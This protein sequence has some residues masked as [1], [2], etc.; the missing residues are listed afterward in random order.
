MRNS[1]FQVSRASEVQLGNCL[2][3]VHLCLH[4]RQAEVEQLLAGV[5]HLHHVAFRQ[6]NLVTICNLQAC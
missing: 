4:G 3:A 1:F 2:S 5:G 6:A